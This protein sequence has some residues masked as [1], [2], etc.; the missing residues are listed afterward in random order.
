[1]AWLY[2][3]VTAHESP[4]RAFQGCTDNPDPSVCTA[5][6]QTLKDSTMCC[7]N[8]AEGVVKAGVS[9]EE[10]ESI[11][12]AHNQYRANVNP[13]ATNMVKMYWDYNIAAVAQHFASACPDHHDGNRKVA[14]YDIGIGQNLAWGYGSWV[15]AIGGWHGEVDD[16]EMGVGS[17]P[18]G[19]AVGH[20]TQ[21]VQHHAIRIGCGYADCA[22]W[23]TYVCNYAHGQGGYSTPYAVGESCAKCPDFCQNNL[24]DCG[25][26]ICQNGGSLNITSCQCECSGLHTGE[27]CQSID[28]SGASDSWACDQYGVDACPVYWNV[29]LECPI[30]CSVCPP[31]T[32]CKGGDDCCSDGACGL[33]EGDCDSNAD[34]ANDLVC[35]TDNCKANFDS[36]SFDSTD[37]CCTSKFE[38][39]L[40]GGSSCVGGDACCTDRGNCGIGEGD[41]D[42]DDDCQ[43]GLVCGRDN[44][45][46]EGFDST[47]DCCKSALGN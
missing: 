47:D 38:V 8:Q 36:T 4:K 20:Y 40:T 41:C 7:Y 39:D 42:T 17:V 37:D 6:Y 5:H 46:G 1:M 14:G 23:K 30:M 9:Q 33:G 43:S 45:V 34:C 28:C 15:S 13:T 16:F 35:G 18:G 21:V 25:S 19:G 10:V 32:A 3:S 12:D 26:K 27:N 31:E 44:C 24:C 29:P 2:Q 22:G 11:V